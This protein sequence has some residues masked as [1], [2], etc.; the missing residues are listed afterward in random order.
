VAVAGVQF[1]AVNPFEP[2]DDIKCLVSE[3]RFAIE[4]VQDDAFKRITD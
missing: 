3:W 2:D 4:R 1:T